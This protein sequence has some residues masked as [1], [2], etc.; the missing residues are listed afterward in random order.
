PRTGWRATP[1][2]AMRCG[3]WKLIQS[4]ETNSFELYNLTEDPGE[5]TNLASI[6]TEVFK[7]L[8]SQLEAWQ[9]STDAPVDFPLNPNY[10]G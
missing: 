10:E 8:K 9:Q 2:S 7:G 5:Q 1:S 4:F 3:E 6:R